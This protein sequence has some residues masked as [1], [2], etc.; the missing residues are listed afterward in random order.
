MLAPDDSCHPSLS[1]R[2][3]AANACRR[4][5]ATVDGRGMQQDSDAGAQQRVSA[6]FESDDFGLR[7]KT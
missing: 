2:A 7:A 4:V 1:P 5:V 3:L 6:E